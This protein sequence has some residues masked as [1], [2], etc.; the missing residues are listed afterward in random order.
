MLIK[1]E[2]FLETVIEKLMKHSI[3]SL[4]TLGLSMMANQSLAN[5]LEGCWSEVKECGSNKFIHCNNDHDKPYCVITDQQ[6]IP[7][8]F[9]M[10]K[11]NPE[12]VHGTIHWRGPKDQA[13]KDCKKK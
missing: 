9:R 13:I 10:N 1:N 3:T 6:H 8:K 5:R 11:G 2:I 7:I 12:R 4:I